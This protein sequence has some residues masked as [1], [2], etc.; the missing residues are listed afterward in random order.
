MFADVIGDAGFGERV[1]GAFGGGERIGADVAD[2][3]DEA[4]AAEVAATEFVGVSSC[5]EDF[6][7]AVGESVEQVP[8]GVGVGLWQCDA[9]ELSGDGVFVFEAGVADVATADAAG[10]GGA[11]DEVAGGESAFFGEEVEVFAGA[12]GFV[13]GLFF[14]EEVFGAL[15]DGAADAGEVFRE[16]RE[17]V[18]HDVDPCA[19]AAD[20]S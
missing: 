8:V 16:I 17:G 1:E 11:A 20:E 6:D 14:D 3:D 19:S 2:A 18:D 7:G 4:V 5:P 12:G 10:F 9:D 15:L 13:E